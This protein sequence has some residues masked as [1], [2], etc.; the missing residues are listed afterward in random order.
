MNE[1]DLAAVLQRLS[2]TMVLLTDRLSA[3]ETSVHGLAQSAAAHG[4]ALETEHRC[5]RD[6]AEVADSHAAALKR[7]VG[8]RSRPPRGEQRN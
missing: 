4:A 2:E 6:L 8:Q 7:I 5:L 1:T 3:V